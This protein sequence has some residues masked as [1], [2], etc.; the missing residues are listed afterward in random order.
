MSNHKNQGRRITEICQEFNCD[1]VTLARVSSL[2]MK[3]RGLLA[4]KPSWGKII[5]WIEG[6]KDILK[7]EIENLNL[8]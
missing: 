8:E 1:A 3:K 5:S 6:N 7:K 4:N 2:L